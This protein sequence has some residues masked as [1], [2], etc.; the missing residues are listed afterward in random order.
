MGLNCEL[1][2]NHSRMSLARYP[3][4]KEFLRVSAVHDVGDAFEFPEQNYYPDWN[5]RRNHW[6]GVYIMDKQTTERVKTWQSH[7]DVWAAGYF[8]HD[9]ADSSTPIS[10]LI[11]RTAGW[12]PGSFRAMAAGRARYTT[13]TTFW[14]NWTNLASG[15]WIG[16]RAC[17]ISIRPGR[18]KKRASS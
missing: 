3:N 18:W 10:G 6:G 15:I 12:Y 1:F 9:W 5:E 11:A 14:K 8:F 7:K 17:F 2:F 16:I 4:G 13:F